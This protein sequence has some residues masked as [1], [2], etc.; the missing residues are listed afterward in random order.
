MNWHAWSST[1]VNESCSSA[2]VKGQYSQ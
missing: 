1:H 2:T